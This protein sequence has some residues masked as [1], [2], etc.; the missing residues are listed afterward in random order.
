M[1]ATYTTVYVQ[2]ITVVLKREVTQSSICIGAPAPYNHVPVN[3]TDSYAFY[4]QLLALLSVYLAP[5]NPTYQR[6]FALS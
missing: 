2:T 1:L 6:L 3:T 5:S 4:Q